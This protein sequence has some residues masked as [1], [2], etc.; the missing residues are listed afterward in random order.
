MIASAGRNPQLLSWQK[1]QSELLEVSS[2]LSLFQGFVFDPW[3]DWGYWPFTTLL[4][5]SWVGW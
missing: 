1:P 3:K 5:T 2:A 4:S